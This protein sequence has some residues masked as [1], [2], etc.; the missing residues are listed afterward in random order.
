MLLDGKKRPRA[1]RFL[2]IRRFAE[3]GDW[4]TIPARRNWKGKPLPDSLP[5]TLEQDDDLACM[6]GLAA[7]DSGALERLYQRHSPLVYALALRMLGNRAEAEELLVDVFW[8]LWDRAPRYDAE[9]SRPLTYLIQLTRSRAID[10]L[11]SRPKLSTI[12]LDTPAGLLPVITENDPSAELVRE[13][14]QAQV[15][16]A[17]GTLNLAQRQVVECAYFDGLSHTEIAAKL[18]QPLGTVKAH[19]RQ[20]LV[21]LREF[22]SRSSV[23]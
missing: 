13:E 2:L 12:A 1:P 15:R 9:R 7:R 6:Q 20:G 21:K 22:F 4:R 5:P 16:R 10:R 18:Q 3:Y 23:G 17:L 14:R 8:E 11:R 19:M